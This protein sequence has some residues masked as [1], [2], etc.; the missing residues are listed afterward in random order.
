MQYK[1]EKALGQDGTGR[2]EEGTGSGWFVG[3]VGGM[4]AL[5]I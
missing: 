1:K 3:W 5:L 2:V 4:A